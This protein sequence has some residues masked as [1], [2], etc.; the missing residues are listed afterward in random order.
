MNILIAIAS[1]H[2]STYEIGEALAAEF[3]EAGHTADVRMAGD[4]PTVRLYDAIVIGSAIYVGGWLPEARTFVE[5]NTDMLRQRPVW[6]FSS[7][8]LGAENPQPQ[9]DPNHLPDLMEATG[10]REHR[11]FVGK[12]DKSTLG[13]TERLMV[14]MVKAPEGDFRDW[15]AISTWANEI[16]AALEVSAEPAGV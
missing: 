15:E 10:A 7:G 13:L 3:R 14:K 1:R 11:I 6:L 16:V 2:G 5:H 12:L 8:P 9:A 4:G